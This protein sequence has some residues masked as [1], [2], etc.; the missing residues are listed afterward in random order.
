MCFGLLFAATGADGRFRDADIDFR[1]R[2][3]MGH[4]GESRR[5]WIADGRRWALMLYYW[6]TESIC[7]YADARSHGQRGLAGEDAK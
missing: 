3:V 6:Q 4:R 1:P 5:F 2:G 7:D